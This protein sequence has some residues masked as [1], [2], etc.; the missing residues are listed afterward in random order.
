MHSRR[1]VRLPNHDYTIGVYFIT[2]VTHKRRCIFGEIRDQRM[3]LSAAGVLARDQWRNIDNLR[4]NICI[5]EFIIMPNHIHAI[6]WLGTEEGAFDFNAFTELPQGSQRKFS[7]SQGPSLSTIIGSYKS[8]LSRLLRSLYGSVDQ[9]WQRDYFEK[10]IRNKTILMGY[11][12][13]IRNNPKNWE[14]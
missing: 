12:E 11:R 2:L 7:G 8:G 1:S 10:I 6:L 9:V 3:F 14:G 5:D 4:P 13:Y